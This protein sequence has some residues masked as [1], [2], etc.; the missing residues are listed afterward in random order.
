[1][2]DS[3]QIVSA[4]VGPIIVISASGLLCLAFY[5]RLTAVVTRLRGF[6]RERLEEQ[7]ELEASGP[8]TEPAI[9]ELRKNVLAMLHTQTE[10][11]RHRAHLIRRTLVCLLSTIMCLALCSLAL[12]LSEVWSPLAGVAVPLFIAGLL[13]L[14]AGACFALLEL[15]YALDPV[16]MEAHVVSQLTRM[17]RSSAPRQ[18]VGSAG[19]R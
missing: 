19:G 3:S 18:P 12:G 5:N 6:D 7:E 8:G 2:H 4:G 17:R 16:E 15:K 14:V 9:R 1:M 10:L 13:L 11:L